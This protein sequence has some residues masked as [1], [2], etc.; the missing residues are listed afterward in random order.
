MIFNET[1]LVDLKGD[2]K[3]VGSDGSTFYGDQLYWDQKAKWIFTDNAFRT[4]LKNNNRTSGKILDSNE[5]LT[6]AL[7]RGASDEFYIKP[8]DE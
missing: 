5:K 7:V 4:N 2:V 3:I 8:K 1:D 6:D